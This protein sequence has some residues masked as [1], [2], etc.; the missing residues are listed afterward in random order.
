MVDQMDGYGP[1]VHRG[2]HS[3]PVMIT[4]QMQRLPCVPSALC[5]FGEACQ[6][7][8]PNVL[9]II[10]ARRVNVNNCLAISELD[11]DNPR[12]P[13]PRAM[14][15]SWCYTEK[16]TEA[17]RRLE[18]QYNACANRKKQCRHN[19]SKPA[20]NA[21]HPRKRQNNPTNSHTPSR[22]K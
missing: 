16:A 18:R 5:T 6:A 17:R 2:S 11:F 8:V 20:S 15:R 3:C 7:Y 4:H 22:I 21:T 19:E 12:E 9:C 1:R 13:E 14:S 10:I